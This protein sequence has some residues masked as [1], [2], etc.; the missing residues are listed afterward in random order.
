VSR[1]NQAMPFCNE[2]VDFI[3]VASR[4]GKGQFNSF[5]YYLSASGIWCDKRNGI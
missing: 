5:L 2:K 4:E 3:R 1:S